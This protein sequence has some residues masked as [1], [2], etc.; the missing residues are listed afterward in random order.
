MRG[1]GAGEQ[2]K[3]GM[4]W[5]AEKE[6]AARPARL[7]PSPPE[8]VAGLFLLSHPEA[9]QPSSGFSASGAVLLEA[10]TSIVPT[11]HVC[12]PA[13]RPV[14]QPQRHHL[15]PGSWEDRSEPRCSQVLW[16]WRG[17]GTDLRSQGHLSLPPA[18]STLAKA[19]LPLPLAG[20][21]S[22]TRPRCRPDR[23]GR[24][25][26]R[27]VLDQGILAPASPPRGSPKS[28]RPRS[29]FSGQ[30]RARRC[31]KAQATSSSRYSCR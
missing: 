17:G 12:L 9:S 11:P 29:W 7:E 30:G 23:P 31:G 24:P 6:C 13:W 28:A 18:S 1:S 4:E 3:S 2:S 19:L 16:S 22:G 5:I 26:Q 14:S 10:P 21:G 8:L 27:A 20:A 25:S 15:C